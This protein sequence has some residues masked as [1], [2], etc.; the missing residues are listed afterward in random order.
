MSGPV[1]S[2]VIMSMSML[3]S[4]WTSNPVELHSHKKGSDP[5]GHPCGYDSNRQ[6]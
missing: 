4:M 1:E 2:L 5:E 3:M 6:S